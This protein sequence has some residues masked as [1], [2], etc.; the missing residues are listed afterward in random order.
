MNLVRICL[1]FQLSNPNS[2]APFLILSMCKTKMKQGPQRNKRLLQSENNLFFFIS[3][4]MSSQ[5]K[6]VTRFA[7]LF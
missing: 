3:E 4:I 6:S 1:L 7:F 2:K 5:E